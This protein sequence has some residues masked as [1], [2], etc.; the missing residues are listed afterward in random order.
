MRYGDPADAEAACR[1]ELEQIAECEIRRRPGRLAPREL[2]RR[3]HGY[4]L[5]PESRALFPARLAQLRA[6]NASVTMPT[7]PFGADKL[8]TDA[9][10][11]H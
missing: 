10:Y 11:E 6:A 9:R 5:L 3:R 7:V 1:A 2:K 4:Q 8:L